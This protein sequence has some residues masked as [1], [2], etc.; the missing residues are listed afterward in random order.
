MSTDYPYDPDLPFA[1]VE[2][3]TGR[4]LAR[5]WIR[6]YETDGIYKLFDKNRVEIVDTTPTPKIP[7][8]AHII[9]WGY[10][11]TYAENIYLISS[12]TGNQWR[13]SGVNHVVGQ[14]ELEIM[15]GDSEV[16]VLKEA[17]ND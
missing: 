6:M 3:A 10:P 8:H 14:A 4:V 13:V 11:R 7:E 2:K 5:T 1:I 17:D 9:S 16:S 15:I 12:D